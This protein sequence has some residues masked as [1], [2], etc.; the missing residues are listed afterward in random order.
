MAGG[1]AERPDAERIVAAPLEELAKDLALENI[2][3]FRVAEKTRH[4]DER[5]GIKG[6]E[7][8]GVAAQEMGV[9]LQRVLLLIQHHAPGD[10]PLDGDGFVEA[11]IHAGM[12]AEEKKNFLELVFSRLTGCRF[13]F[14]ARLP[15][16]R[17]RTSGSAL[18]RRRL[19]VLALRRGGPVLCQ[20][21]GFTRLTRDVRM[22]RDAGEFFSNVLRFENEIHA[23]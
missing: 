4:A 22:L 1:T 12:V 8:F 7:F 9:V 11:K 16:S 20:G 23:A 21:D 18:W 13:S 5:V 15:G 19:I 17:A 14:G 3:S 6:V 2:E 10:A